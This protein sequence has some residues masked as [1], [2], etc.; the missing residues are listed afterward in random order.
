MYPRFFNPPKQSYFLFGPRGTGKSTWLKQQYPDAYW[1]DLLD[2][3]SFRFFSAGAERL[4]LLLSEFPQKKIIVID[5]VQKVP[6]LLNVVHSLIEEKK[7]YQFVMTGSSARKLKKQGVNLL[8]GRALLK[9]MT[10]FF[11][12]ELGASFDFA[13]HLRFGMLPIVLDSSSPQEVLRAYAGVYLKEEV[14]S[15]GI[16]RNVGDFARFLEVMSFSHASLINASNISREC[17]IARKTVDS[18]LLILEDLLLSFQLTVFRRKAKRNLGTHPKFYFFD[19]GVYYSIRPKNLF[20]V[21]SESEGAALE[22]LVAQH[23]KGWV[24]AQLE[25]YQLNFW[26]TTSKVDV[27][28]IVSG[29]TCFCAIEVK[30]GTTIHPGDFHG[31]ETFAEDYPEAERILLYRGKHRYK[32]RGV[33]CCPVDEFLLKIDPLS[34]FLPV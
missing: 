26:Q 30:N 28:F 8:G 20:D 33:L 10:P 23:L 32:E 4:T 6:E 12:A 17:Q 29:P 2:P 19:S 5:E 27:D 24:D 34:S 18:Y 22:G 21:E 9:H 11:A 31:L 14:Q 25:S 1:V 3:E 15:E 13:K 16:V 7:G